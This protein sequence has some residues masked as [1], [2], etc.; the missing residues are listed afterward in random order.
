VTNVGQC[1]WQVLDRHRQWPCDAASHHLVRDG[2]DVGRVAR[3]RAGY[4][5]NRVLLADVLR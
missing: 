4:A 3:S 1:G 2:N 5:G